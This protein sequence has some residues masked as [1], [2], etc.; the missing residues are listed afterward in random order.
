VVGP[1]GVHS[2][3]WQWS[4]G[5][6]VDTWFWVLRCEKYAEGWVFPT[7]HYSQGMMY[8]WMTMLANRYIGR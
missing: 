6:S 7:A 2:Y 1:A 4:A 8:I 5:Q 3:G